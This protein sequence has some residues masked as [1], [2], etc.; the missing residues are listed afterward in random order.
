MNAFHNPLFTVAKA[1][2]MQREHLA[3]WKPRLS[4]DCY[5]ALFFEAQMHNATLPADATG[6]DVFRGQQIT[7]FVANWKPS[8]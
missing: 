7:E 5:N 4:A 1:I 3:Q 2:E 6:Y 8:N